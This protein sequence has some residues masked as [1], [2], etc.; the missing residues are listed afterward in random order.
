M[1]NVLVMIAD[2]KKIAKR[3]IGLALIFFGILLADHVT[4]MLIAIL[5]VLYL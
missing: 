3:M 2:I 4:W 1:K 5:L